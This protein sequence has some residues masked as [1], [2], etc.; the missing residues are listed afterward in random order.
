MTDKITVT[1]IQYDDLTL[2]FINCA[3]WACHLPQLICIPLKRCETRVQL[4]IV[5]LGICNFVYQTD[6]FLVHIKVLDIEN[7][8]VFNANLYELIHI[9]VSRDSQM[10]RW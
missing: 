7:M 8:Y 1:R 10:A 5:S 2:T 4:D 3:S 9:F 6:H